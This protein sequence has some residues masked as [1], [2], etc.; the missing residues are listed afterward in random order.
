VNLGP[1][2]LSL[3][4]ALIATAI[5]GVL[6]VGLA[7]LMA[8]TR[9]F[10][11]DIVDALI[12]APMVL[13]PTVLGWYLLVAL[14]RNSALGRAYESL[15]GDTIVFTRTGAVVAAAVAAFPFIVKSARAAM[16]DVDLRYI[17]AARTLGANPPRVLVTIILP[18][19]KGG[20]ASGLALGFARALGEFGMTMMLGGNLP[21]TTRTGALA[22]YDAWQGNRDSDAS[23]LAAAM[24][25]L[26]LATLYVF[27]RLSHRP[28]HGF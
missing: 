16:E 8:Q 23:T 15:T 21:G 11:S 13:P 6:G 9:F 24:T 3:E 5:A 2:W 22:I 28:R 17:G 4:V 18:L 12:T 19:S 14:G 25:V 10:G 20:I 1:L 26:G 7:A 27:N